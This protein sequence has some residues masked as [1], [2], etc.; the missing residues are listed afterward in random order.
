MGQEWISRPSLCSY[1][2]PQVF[3]HAGRSLTGIILSHSL[4]AISRSRQAMTAVL[5]D[6]ENGYVGQFKRICP[7]CVRSPTG[8]QAVRSVSPVSMSSSPLPERTP[9]DT[10]TDAVE[11][12]ARISPNYGKRTAHHCGRCTMNRPSAFCIAL[13]PAQT[14]HASYSQPV[15][16]TPSQHTNRCT[17][18]KRCRPDPAGPQRLPHP[19]RP[20]RCCTLQVL[21]L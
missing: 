15:G 4:S 5:P 17:I 20:N 19:G 10:K 6:S 21:L 9:G 2:G 13:K 12:V 14:G 16:C 7:R 11:P 18:P 3:R 8:P 1:Y